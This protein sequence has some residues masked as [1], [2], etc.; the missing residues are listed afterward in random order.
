MNLLSVKSVLAFLLG[1]MVMAASVSAEPIFEQKLASGQA[2]AL[3]SDGEVVADNFE[4]LSDATFNT[5]RWYG[6]YEPEDRPSNVAD[7]AVWVPD[8]NF[9]IDI[10]FRD[11]NG[12][13]DQ[14]SDKSLVDVAYSSLL[15]EST[16]GVDDLSRPVLKYSVTVSDLALTAGEYLL[17]ITAE[18]DGGLDWWW[19][20]GGESEGD[21][22]VL[23][24]GEAVQ[25]DADRAFSLEFVEVPLLPSSLLMLAGLGALLGARRR[26]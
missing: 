13:P 9:D 24:Q 17:S 25:R 1:L 19:A 4:L 20:A 14:T 3:S 6:A 26:A 5:I 16:V 11:L 12:N 8:F 21:H 22:F 18:S 7:D 15:V 23:M 10:F 2:G